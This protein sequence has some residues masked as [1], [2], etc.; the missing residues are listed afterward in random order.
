MQLLSGVKID[1]H[2][3]AFPLGETSNR[4]GWGVMGSINPPP[5]GNVAPTIPPDSLGINKAPQPR[6]KQPS[7]I[8]GSAMRKGLG[9]H[10]GAALSPW[11]IQSAIARAKAPG[12]HWE[13]GE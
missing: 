10:T 8:D 11:R 1:S 9:S 12:E 7:S 5:P 2:H 6:N 4:N 13:W 3:D